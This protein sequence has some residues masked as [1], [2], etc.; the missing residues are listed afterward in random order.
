MQ[1]PALPRMRK[2]PGLPDEEVF[3]KTI[4]LVPPFAETLVNCT[5]SG[6]VPDD[7]VISIAVAPELL[8]APFVVV[9]VPELFAA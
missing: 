5:L 2:P 9:I 6:V 8:I 7:C 1:F 3:V 4:P